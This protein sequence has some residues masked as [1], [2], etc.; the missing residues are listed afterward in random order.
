[1]SLSNWHIRCV[2]SSSSS[3]CS[4][5]PFSS[6]SSLSFYRLSQFLFFAN[7]SMCN[8]ERIERVHFI[9]YTKCRSIVS[10]RVVYVHF[11]LLPLTHTMA[12]YIRN[13]NVNSFNFTSL[14]HIIINIYKWNLNTRFIDMFAVWWWL[15]CTSIYCRSECAHA[16]WLTISIYSILN[17]SIFS[18]YDNNWR[19]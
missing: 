2:I 19:L 14:Y 17:Q 10:A 16:N 4:F 8:N 13:M 15:S 3:S 18:P 7:V 6:S 12:H 5:S 9:F 11:N 1:M